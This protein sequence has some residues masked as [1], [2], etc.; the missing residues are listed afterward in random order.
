M[1]KPYQIA[2]GRAV[3]RVRQWAEEKNPVVQLMLPIPPN[4]RDSWRAHRLES[5]ETFADLG[6]RFNASA[7]AVSSANRE[8]LPEAGSWMAIPVSYPG[9]RTPAVAKSTSKPGTRTA[10][11]KGGSKATSRRSVA[12]KAAP[13]EPKSVSKTAPHRARAARS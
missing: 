8:E 10:V 2:A 12:S 1:K 3:Q 9:D 6:K 7:A 13:S 4:R 5:G 11:R